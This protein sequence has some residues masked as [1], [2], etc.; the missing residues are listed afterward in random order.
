MNRGEGDELF[1][2][3]NRIHLTRGDSA[4]FDLTIRDRVTGSVFIPGTATA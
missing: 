1:V 2:V 3:K 4:E